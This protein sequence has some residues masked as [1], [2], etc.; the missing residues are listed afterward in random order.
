MPKYILLSI[1]TLAIALLILGCEPEGPA[2]ATDVNILSEPALIEPQIPDPVEP[3]TVSN[4]EPNDIELTQ[5][6]EPN[7]PPAVSQVEP[8]PPLPPAVETKPIDAFN[9]NFAPIFEIYVNDEGQVDYNS[10]RRKKSELREL[11]KKLAELKPAVYEEWTAAEKIAFWINTYNLKM[12]DIII[13]NYPIESTR[14]HRLIWP[15]SSIRH[16]P[17]RNEV[18]P[19][20]WNSYKFIVMDEEFTLTEIEKRFFRNQFKDPRVFLALTLAS[21]DSPPLRNEPYLGQSLDKQLDD[22]AKKFLASPSGLRIDRD[23]NRVLLSVVFE[24]S[25]PW[26][27]NEFLKKYAID[28]KFK[29]QPP[30]VRAALNF[31]I[32]YL[33]EATINYLETG[34]YDVRYKSYDWR[35]NEQ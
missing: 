35:L 8:P 31:A 27:G 19:P 22:Q 29:S 4:A 6:A 34:N 16:I 18:G 12:L 9:A 23:S 7:E 20:K 17:P 13:D 3:P 26:Y 32:G 24:P 5:P 1:L 25:L 21:R 15:P 2:P 14:I 11:F 30:V 10:L 33:P 28:K